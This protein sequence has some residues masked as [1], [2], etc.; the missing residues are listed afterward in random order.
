L[1]SFQVTDPIAALQIIDDLYRVLIAQGD[2]GPARQI[3]KHKAL[4]ASSK[5]QDKLVQDRT[6]SSSSGKGK[7]CWDCGKPDLV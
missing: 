3:A 5:E 1:G 2:Y 6:S 7:S 4:L